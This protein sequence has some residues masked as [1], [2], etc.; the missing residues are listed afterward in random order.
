MLAEGAKVT[1]VSARGGLSFAESCALARF[2]AT[3]GLVFRSSTGA[4]V[5]N[6]LP[7][8]KSGRSGVCCQEA[9]LRWMSS[10]SCFTHPT[11]LTSIRPSCPIRNKLG[12]LVSP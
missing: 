2:P 8:L 12:T 4:E 9:S 3:A 6:F 10:T 1:Q 5:A 11:L 7:G